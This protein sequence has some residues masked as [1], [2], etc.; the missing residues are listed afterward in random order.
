MSRLFGRS[1]SIRIGSID[2]S[3]LDVDLLVFKSRKREPNRATLT[4][5]GLSQTTRQS[6]EGAGR[7]RIEIRAGY[8][9]DPPILFV[10]DTTKE[11]AV[12]EADGVEVATRLEAKDQGDAYQRARINR[13]FAAGATVEDVLRVAV[14][15]LGIGD[16][17]LGDFAAGLRL[18]NGAANFPEG[19]VASGAAR[20]VVDAIVRGAGL[21]WSVQNGVLTVRERGRPLQNTATLLS[22]DTGLVGAPTAD[23]KGVVSATCLIQPGLDP[24]RRVVLDTRQFQGGYVVRSVEYSGSTSAAD[25][26]AKLE[27]EPY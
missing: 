1:W 7:P 10:G 20:D 12:T 17:N 19:F 11:G 15:A 4:V 14:R 8:G 22:P 6:I 5:Y 2:V 18:E 26:Y 27:L 25:W 13:A 21:R 23:P 3:E 16:G 9:Q 24:G